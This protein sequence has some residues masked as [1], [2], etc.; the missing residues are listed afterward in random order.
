MILICNEK[1]CHV[2][3]S[4]LVMYPAIRTYINIGTKQGTSTTSQMEIKQISRAHNRSCN[5]TMTLHHF[6]HLKEE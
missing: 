3:S 5:H 1:F 4:T 6:F 2:S